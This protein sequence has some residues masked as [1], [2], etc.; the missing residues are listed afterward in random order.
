PSAAYA[1]DLSCDGNLVR[2]S[3]SDS[4]GF[5]VQRAFNDD[6]GV[7]PWSAGTTPDTSIG[8]FQISAAS[9]FTIG[10]PRLHKKKGTAT[11]PVTVPGPATLSLHHQPV[12]TPSS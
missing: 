12:P 7:A 11:E 8:A 4:S 2:A 5:F 9:L 6:D 10:K 1:T 3:S